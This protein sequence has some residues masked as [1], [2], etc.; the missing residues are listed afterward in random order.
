MY[1]GSS[2]LAENPAQHAVR[3]ILTGPSADGK[4]DQQVEINR[5][6]SMFVA[7]I[8]WS[9]LIHTGHTVR[10]QGHS[11][12]KWQLHRFRN[13]SSGIHVF[14]RRSCQREVQL[15]LDP[16][17]WPRLGRIEPTAQRSHSIWSRASL[18]DWEQSS[19]AKDHM[20]SAYSQCS[21]WLAPSIIKLWQILGVPRCW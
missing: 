17:W 3:I 2:A 15:G 19:L 7:W 8:L 9:N 10:S 20:P 14:Q 11:Q 4:K 5:S 1:I 13:I 12:R 6:R 18:V 16:I 21:Q